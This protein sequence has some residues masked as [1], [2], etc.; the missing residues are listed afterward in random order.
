MKR[1]VFLVSQYAVIFKSLTA[2]IAAA[3]KILSIYHNSSADKMGNLFFHVACIA[4]FVSRDT[5]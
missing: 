5:Q 2:V 1:P 4:P 3:K